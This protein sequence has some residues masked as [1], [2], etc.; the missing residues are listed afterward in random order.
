M[1]GVVDENQ[2]VHVQSF[3]NKA[4]PVFRAVSK[5]GAQY[6]EVPFKMEVSLSKDVCANVQSCCA[7]R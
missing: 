1:L 3:S 5:D 2:G 7:R 6:L 4:A